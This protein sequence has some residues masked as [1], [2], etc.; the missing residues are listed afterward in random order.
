VKTFQDS[1]T[2][3]IWAFEDSDNVTALIDR[4]IAPVT[5]K[6]EVIPQPTPAHTWNGSGWDAPTL[7]ATVGGLWARV[8][9]IFK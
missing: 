6:Y 9:G 7:G 1:R 4:G 3:Y 2:G 8:K 5:L